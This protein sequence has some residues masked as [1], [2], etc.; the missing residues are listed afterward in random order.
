MA[1]RAERSVIG[2]AEGWSPASF[3]ELYRELWWPML[4]LATGLVDEP[5]LAEDV[6]QDAF[7]AVYRKW[8][9]IRDHHAAVSYLRTAVVNASRS[10][11]RRRITARKHAHAVADE[12]T[13]PADHTVLLG[14][15][16]DLVRDALDTLPDRQ[17][18]VL[19]LRYLAD[20]SDAE[21][22]ESTGLSE[23]GVRSAASR[24]LAALRAKL[25]GR[26]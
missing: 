1:A 19:T 9:S 25:G 22:A 4:W 13:E 16:H 11:L 18:E 15:E 5:A 12:G 3:D 8:A 21:I 20:L 26:P 7:A 17:R 24:G 2:Q 6:V 23:V 14:V 10:A